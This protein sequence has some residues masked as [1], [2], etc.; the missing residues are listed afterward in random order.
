MKRIIMF[1]II[2]GLLLAGCENEK[3]TSV[4]VV[5]NEANGTILTETILTEEILIEEIEEEEAN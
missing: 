2:C 4:P 3:T 1:I 5:T